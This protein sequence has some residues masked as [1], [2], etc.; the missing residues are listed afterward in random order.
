MEVHWNMCIYTHDARLMILGVPLFS[1]WI[2]IFGTLT[3][4]HLVNFCGLFKTYKNSQLFVTTHRNSQQRGY[5][6]VK[7][8][9]AAMLGNITT[10]KTWATRGGGG[11]PPCPKEVLGTQGFFWKRFVSKIRP[12]V[13]GAQKC[14]LLWAKSQHT[15]T[16]THITSS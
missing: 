3:M 4:L 11:K 7:A 13:R 5:F 15:H 1:L 14:R 12:D 9:D 16:H 2:I 6:A 10:N 8:P